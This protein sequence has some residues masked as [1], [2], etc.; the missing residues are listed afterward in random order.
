[1]KI[2]KYISSYNQSSRNGQSI[3]YIV[4][5]YVGA[6]SSAKNNCIYFS[7]GN[8]NA[9]AHFFV[10]SEIWQCIPENMAAWHCGGGLQDTGKRMNGGNYGASLY[11]IC[12]NQNSIGIELCCKVENG[13]VVPRLDAID[14]SK[15]L[16]AYLMKK[17]NGLKKMS[18]D[19]LI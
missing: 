18:S 10:D 12:T 6:V 1:M 3:K 16:V 2:N 4:I 11:R 17:Y 19:T 14:T 9:S 5:H 15:E 13:K 8:R 7:G